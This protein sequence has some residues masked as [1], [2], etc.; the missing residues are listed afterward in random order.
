MAVNKMFKLI[1]S[2]TLIADFALNEITDRDNTDELASLKH[3]E[4]G[5][6]P[7]RHEGHAMLNGMFGPCDQDPRLHDIANQHCR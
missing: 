1:D 7:L 5:Y 6:T 4:M 3:R 2:E